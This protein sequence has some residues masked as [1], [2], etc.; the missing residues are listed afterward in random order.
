MLRTLQD[1]LLNERSRKG[2]KAIVTMK[3][4]GVMMRLVLLVLCRKCSKFY[5]TLIKPLTALCRGFDN[6]ITLISI[7][8]II[9]YVLFLAIASA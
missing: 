5:R 2:K 4:I 6:G 8:S 1:P 7:F 3:S 9:Y